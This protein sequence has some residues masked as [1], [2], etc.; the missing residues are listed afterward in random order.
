MASRSNYISTECSTVIS[1]D[2]EQLLT[3]SLLTLTNCAT[4]ITI[5]IIYK[6]YVISINHI[7]TP[8]VKNLIIQVTQSLLKQEFDE[9]N[10]D[11]SNNYTYQINSGYFLFYEETINKFV[12]I[13][14]NMMKK[15]LKL[16]RQNKLLGN[17]DKLNNALHILK[18]I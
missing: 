11:L 5:Q 6:L 3:T 13:P 1:G 12:A 2:G 16:N 8:S 17:D 10:L 9:I 7:E 15:S 14:V 18:N 4:S